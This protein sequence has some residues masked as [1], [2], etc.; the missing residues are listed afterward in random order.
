MRLANIP[1]LVLAL[2]FAAFAYFQW[3]DPDSAPWLILYGAV[4]ATFGFAAVGRN[5]LPVTAGLG[6]ICLAWSLYHLPALFE[7]ATNTDN[8]G[9]AQGMSYEYPYI[10]RSREFGG[11]FV[12]FLALLWLFFRQRRPSEQA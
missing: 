2:L 9:L 11:L 8:M 4:A 3:N 1:A 10:E 7:F 6:I 5:F 12:A